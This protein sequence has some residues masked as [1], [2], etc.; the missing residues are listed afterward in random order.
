MEGMNGGMGSKGKLSAKMNESAEFGRANQ[1]I[2]AA[3]K[4]RETE[5]IRK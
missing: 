2:T 5:N 4:Q 3:I 1:A